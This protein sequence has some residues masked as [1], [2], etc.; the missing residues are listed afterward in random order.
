MKKELMD[1]LVD[2]LGVVTNYTVEVREA[3]P[4]GNHNEAIPVCVISNSVKGRFLVLDSEISHKSV[5]DLY[6][7]LTQRIEETLLKAIQARCKNRGYDVEIEAARNEGWCDGYDTA[8]AAGAEDFRVQ[9]QELLT[10]NQYSKVN[11]LL[12]RPVK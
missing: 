10:D 1:K 8:F 11:E 4:E 3:V 9:V 2:I 6:E 12:K 5:K 7:L